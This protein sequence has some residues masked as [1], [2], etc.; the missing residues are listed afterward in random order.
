ME[1]KF[2]VVLS[3]SRIAAYERGNWIT[4]KTKVC[5]S[6]WLEVELCSGL[7]NY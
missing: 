5:A 1:N 7:D 2:W 4:R 3:I 6:V